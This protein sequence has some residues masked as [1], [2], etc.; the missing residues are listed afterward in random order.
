MGRGFRSGK[1]RRTPAPTRL[2][3]ARHDLRDDELA[4]ARRPAGPAFAGR[5][6]LQ[7]ALMP[8]RLM[9][10]PHLASSAFM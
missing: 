9:M 5:R 4:A 3:H 7:S 6:G 8:A 10:G 1:M 2:R